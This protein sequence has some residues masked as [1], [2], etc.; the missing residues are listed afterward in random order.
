MR[1]NCAYEMRKSNADSW[2]YTLYLKILDRVVLPMELVMSERHAPPCNYAPPPLSACSS[3]GY[4][5]F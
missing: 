2:L 5:I 4:A 3:E 1:G